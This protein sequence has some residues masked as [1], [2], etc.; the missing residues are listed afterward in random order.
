MERVAEVPLIS[1][2]TMYFEE[3]RYDDKQLRKL[4]V[5]VTQEFG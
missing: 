4:C 1:N 5:T 3:E 2:E